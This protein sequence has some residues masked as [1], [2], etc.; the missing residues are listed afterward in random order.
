[1]RSW[2]IGR[3]LIGAAVARRL[4]PDRC[5]SPSTRITWDDESDRDA[6]IHAAAA[7]FL[8][9]VGDGPWEVVWCAGAG[10]VGTGEA[11][12]LA[13]ARAVRVLLNA[14]ATVRR[15]GGTV[16]LA[17]S[18]AVYAGS[19]GAPFHEGSPV[20]PLSPYGFTKL[21]QEQAVTAWASQTGNRVVIG[22][23]ANVYGPGQDLGKPQG[24]V[25]RVCLSLLL[26]TPLTLY[27]PL[28]TI[29]D[30]VYVEDCAA[31]VVAAVDDA[32]AQP[33]GSAS[34]RLI[35][36][37]HGVTIGHLLDVG[38]R[39]VK[40]RLPVVTVPSGPGVNQASDL[41]LHPRH[42]FRPEL[43]SV[44]LPVGRRLTI[45]RLLVQH[46][47]GWATVSVAEKASVPQRHH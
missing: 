43:R 47:T 44:S 37:G 14:L 34:V 39:V 46:Q 15:S 18:S 28:D 22:R 27:V 1:M 5:W 9:A 7:E 30:Y 29:R 3:G 21:D 6:R 32:A 41:R 36:T 20:A 16:F 4:G 40:R 38:R 33:P 45:D 13:E 12:L 10:V 17:S 2:V 42:P 23:I 35:A 19:V 11:G 26:Q 8:D 31:M 25:S 24:L